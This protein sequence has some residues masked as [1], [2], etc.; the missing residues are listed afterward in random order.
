V[1]VN[2]HHGA[3]QLAHHLDGRPGLHVL[4]EPELLGTGGALASAYHRGLLGT[5]AVLVT[6]AD[7]LVHPADLAR[8][9]ARLPRAGMVVGLVPA[10]PG[11]LTVRLDGDAATPDPAGPWAPAGVHALRAGVLE[12][13]PPRP[14]SLVDALLAPLWRRGEV[15]GVVLEHPWADAG[16]RHR[17]LAASAGLLAGRWPYRLP[18]GRLLRAVPGGGPVFLADG[19]A[20]HPGALLAGPVVLDQGSRVGAH[21]VVTRTV[22]LPGASVG[23]GAHVSGSILGPGATVPPGARVTT[24]LLPGPV[25]GPG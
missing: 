18:P 21:A 7:L 11:L 4:H 20:A 16:T 5:G 3:G 17:F 23:D 12:P 8:L 2:T 19:A 10:R 15:A 24:A 9:A 1:V 6:G 14:A 22:A 13:V 25:E